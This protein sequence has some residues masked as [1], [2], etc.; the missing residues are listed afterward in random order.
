MMRELR[1][2][3]KEQAVERSGKEQ[4]KQRERILKGAEAGT[5]LAYF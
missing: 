4:L 5:K 3:K 1:H 2:D